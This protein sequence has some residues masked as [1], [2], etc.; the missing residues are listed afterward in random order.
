MLSAATNKLVIED[1][2]SDEPSNTEEVPEDSKQLT[3]DE[4]NEENDGSEILNEEGATSSS[5]P[6]VCLIV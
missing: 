6:E 1:K 4:R 2:Q 5:E 3:T